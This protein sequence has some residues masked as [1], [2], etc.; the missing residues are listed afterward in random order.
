MTPAGIRRVT[1]PTLAVLDALL[2]AGPDTE[3][4]G[5]AIIKA[6]GHA[7]PTV[8]KILQRLADS[9][10]LTVRWDDTTQQPG[11]PPRRR[12]YTLTP[13]GAEQARELLDQR[14]DHR[15]QAPARRPGPV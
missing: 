9:A 2:A 6:T 1:A 13:A 5:W 8:Y 10:L 11:E 14:A 3:L 4:H 7:G 15:Q 12:Y